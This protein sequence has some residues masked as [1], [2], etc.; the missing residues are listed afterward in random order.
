MEKTNFKLIKNLSRLLF[1]V[2]L[3]SALAFSSSLNAQCSLMCDDEYNASLN[4]DGEHLVTFDNLISINSSSCSLTIEGFV[5]DADGNE[6]PGNIVTCEHIGTNVTYELRALNEDGTVAN[7]CWGEITVEDKMPPVLTCLESDLEVDCGTDFDSYLEVVSV[8]GLHTLQ[9]VDPVTLEPTPLMEFTDNCN[10]VELVITDEI[11]VTA[12]SELAEF[13]DNVVR[14]VSRRYVARDIYNNNS[15]TSCWIYVNVIMDMAMVEGPENVTGENAL[16][17]DEPYLVDENGNPSPIVTGYPFND[18]N[19]NGTLDDGESEIDGTASPECGLMASYTDQTIDGPCVD[20]YVRTWT[21]IT[22]SCADSDIETFTQ[23]IEVIDETAPTFD[24]VAP[25]K[26]TTGGHDCESI[27]ALNYP[28]NIEDS[29]DNFDR[30]TVSNPDNNM[31]IDDLQP[32]QTFT[33][34]VGIHRL[35]Y[36]AYDECGN[37]SEQEAYVL[38]EDNTAP[39][40]VCDQHTT[41]SVTTDGTAWLPAESL[42]D[43]SY[44][45]CELVDH[46][47]K[48]MDNNCDCERPELSRYEYLGEYGG[49]HLYISKF[50]TTFNQANKFAEAYEGRLAEANTPGKMAWIYNNVYTPGRS[51][52][53]V[54]IGLGRDMTDNQYPVWSNGVQNTSSAFQGLNLPLFGIATFLEGITTIDAD[55]YFWPYFSGVALAVDV[56]D[57]TYSRPEAIYFERTSS[58]YALYEFPASNI[59]WM[60]PFADSDEDVEMVDIEGKHILELTDVCGF[61]D[62]AKFCCVD[63][64]GGPQM[65]TLRV[66]DAAGNYNDCMVE[67]TVQDKLPAQ[68]T[69]PE[70]QTVDCGYVFDFENLSET[71]GSA[72]VTDNCDVLQPV[73]DYTLTLDDC[74]SGELVRTF[75][76]GDQTCTQ[77]IYIEPIDPFNGPVFWPSDVSIT[78]CANPGDPA[79]SP[80]E[81]GRPLWNDGVCA[82]V[83]ANYTDEVFYINNPTDDACFKI[84]RTWTV[85]DWCQYNPPFGQPG[86]NPELDYEGYRRWSDVQ[87]I[88]VKDDEAPI[89]TSDCSDLSTCTYDT[90]CAEGSLILGATAQDGCTINLNWNYQVDLDND[91]T[92]DSGYGLSASG[93]GNVINVANY[94]DTWPVGTHRIRYTFEDR[95]GN[96]TYCDQIFSIINCKIPSIYLLDGLVVTLMPV[97]ADQ[98]GE[99]EGGMAEIWANDFDKGSAHPCGYELYFSFTEMSL[100]PDGSVNYDFGKM[101]D[102]DDLGVNE[103]TIWVGVVTADGQLLQDNATTVLTVQDNQGICPDG[104]MPTGIVSGDVYVTGGMLPDVEVELVGSEF[105][106]EMTSTEGHYAFPSMIVGGNYSVIPNKEDKVSNGVSTIDIVLIQQHILGVKEITDP[107]LL[108]AADANNDSQINGSDLLELRKVVL[109]VQ[110]EF[111]NNNAWRFVD[112]TFEFVDGNP[113]ATQYPESYIIDILAGDMDVDFM[114]VKIGDINGSADL[115]LRGEDADTRS[116]IVTTFNAEDVNYVAGQTV[117]MPINVDAMS[118]NGVQFTLNY[119]ASA[120]EFKGINGNAVDMNESNYGTTYAA[121]GQVTV[122]W[123][124]ANAEAVSGSLF[125]AQFVAKSNGQL[126]DHVSITSDVTE[127]ELFANG[128]VTDVELEFTSRSAA[129]AVFA[130]EQN[131]PNPFNVNTTVE[132]TLPVAGN[133][134]FTITDVSGKTVKTINKLFNRGVNTITV[135]AAELGN[136]GVFYYTI[137][138][139]EYTATKKMVLID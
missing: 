73:E 68:L 136:S 88:K 102:C 75:T 42:D 52:S 1:G 98:D 16:L 132:F 7:M 24:P 138:S 29:C 122:S 101:Y 97:D 94:R 120:L 45:E 134:T 118:L 83:G 25:I 38:I 81:L 15:L 3:L 130:L 131:T 20:K 87:V 66:I 2:F 19:G 137:K 119:D 61:S 121:N 107:Y 124:K 112:K 111:T 55:T 69:C 100:N 79:F 90:E 139:G 23:L 6:V 95:C 115:N 80:D 5:I 63:A 4:E 18:T 49:S 99:P 104:S 57:A 129:D 114:G 21:V 36:R 103:E 33:F 10:P 127:A 72:T 106:N 110:D 85:I 77:T 53:L 43:G 13:G 14:R 67:V 70:D 32:G 89:I 96:A 44:D 125:T 28:E 48:R 86:N 65:V 30:I 27:V 109:R 93:T 26:A 50:N 133:G 62:H 78:A 91:G 40:A 113:F 39:V 116:S 108:I 58:P 35:I 41:V 17:C 74:G 34:D 56:L 51:D 71:F 82:L 8:D 128:Q 54:W 64:V 135:D 123:S 59:E 46:V 37:Y 84:I 12:C 9:Y 22:W 60:Y 92:F 105:G 31:Y 117:E 11:D 126:A 47:V 76:F